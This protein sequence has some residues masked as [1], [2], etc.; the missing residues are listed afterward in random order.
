[1]TIPIRDI[2][3]EQL[4]SSRKRKISKAQYERLR[5]SILAVGLIEP[6]LVF[7]E[8]DGYTILSGNQRYNVLLEMEAKTAPCIIAKDKKSFLGGAGEGPS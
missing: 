2:A 8:D 1:M 3:L 5:S 6:L 4:R 7:P